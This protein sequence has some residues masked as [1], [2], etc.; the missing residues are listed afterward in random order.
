MM[1][2]QHW[3]LSLGVAGGHMQHV[4]SKKGRGVSTGR[5]F[6]LDME[7]EGGRAGSWGRVDTGRHRGD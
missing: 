5:W 4:G 1:S 3:F 2:R 6:E 7:G